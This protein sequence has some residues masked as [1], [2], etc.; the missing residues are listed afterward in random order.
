[1]EKINLEK[2]MQ[3][4]FD[5]AKSSLNL[6]TTFGIIVLLINILV[7]FV[8]AIST[9]LV[10][11]VA[12]FTILNMIFQW[13]SDKLRGTAEATLRK[14]DLH[15]GLGWEISSRE[16]T[17][18]LASA[19]NSVKKAARS[20]EEY[21]YFASTQ[22][23]GPVRLLE[24]LEESAWWT[25]NQAKRMS[26]YVGVFGVVILVIA[27]LTLIVALQN[28]PSQTSADNIAK[29]TIV[30]IVFI[31]SGGYIRLAFDYNLLFHS[32]K[33]IENQ[34]HRLRQEPNISEIEAIK[35]LHDYQI[36]RA[37]GPLFPSWLWR[38]VRTELNELWQTR[39]SG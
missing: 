4:Q 34:A 9:Y 33:E 15:N 31:F 29:I 13:R 25:W 11:V 8:S 3:S 6:A 12:G 14:F 17:N 39:L 24:N 1:M 38:M 35:L 23:K 2:L 18:L 20:T 7:T 30:V 21:T 27:F 32:A 19:P 22:D 5:A 10:I 26:K 16:I 36:I 28:T 37:N